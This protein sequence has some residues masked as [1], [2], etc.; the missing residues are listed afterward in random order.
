[1]LYKAAI[2]VEIFNA[3]FSST[4]YSAPCHIVPNNTLQ[5]EWLYY[6]R[7]YLPCRICLCTNKCMFR[8]S[9]FCSLVILLGVL[10]VCVWFVIIDVIK[11]W[12]VFRGQ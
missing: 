9:V 1:M 10:R 11:L 6:L 3:C 5:S 2:L 7:G 12:Y 4:F 8:R